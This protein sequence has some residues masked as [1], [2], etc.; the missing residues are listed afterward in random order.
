ML[1]K[2]SLSSFV[3][4]RLT[5]QTMSTYFPLAFQCM[6]GSGIWAMCVDLYLAS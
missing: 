5:L 3:L 6:G 1:L 4:I 2:V